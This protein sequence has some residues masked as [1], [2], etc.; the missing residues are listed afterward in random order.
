MSN[1][2][3]LVLEDEIPLQNA[4]KIKLGK[5]GFDVVT[6][7]TV[8]QAKNH[9]ADIEGIDVI[10]IDHYLLGRETGLDFVAEV[11]NNP[12]WKKIPIFVVSNTASPDKIK[13]YLGLGI[14]RY[15]TKSD[16]KLDTIID[17]I[18]NILDSGVE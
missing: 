7:R 1:K 15:Y 5:S 13:A 18:K 12:K 14:N 16:F 8:D 6:A 2:T 3:V 9:L 4:I 11:K 17:E 10:W